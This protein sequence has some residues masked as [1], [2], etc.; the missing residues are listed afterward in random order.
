VAKY[1]TEI[2][3]KIDG[4]E[5]S[6]DFEK[7][8]AEVVVDTSLHLPDMFA[9]ELRD[10]DLKW[11]DESALLDIGNEVV[12]SFKTAEEGA[13]GGLAAQLITG[14]ITAIEPRF[15]W[16]GKTSLMIRGYD[17][18]HR[19]HRGKQTRTF[20][21]KKDSQV[22][23]TIAGE[24]G[25]TASADATS[26]TYDY[27][28]QSNQTNMEF[29]T[30][31]AER[32]GYQVYC[33][34]GTLFFKKGDAN[35]GDGPTLE[36]GDDLHSFRPRWT[37][38][39]QAD[40]VV[41]RSW[42]PKNKTAI[43]STTSPPGT[44]NQGG[45]TATGGS[46]ASSAFSSATQVVADRPV[47]TADEASEIATGLS[48]DISREFVQAEGS[49]VGN[50]ELKA[51][52][53]IMIEG[54]GTRFSGYYLVTSA[55]HI[56]NK[57]G[58]ETEFSMTGRHP[59]TISHLLGV[60]GNGHSLDQGRVMGV[61]P[62]LVTNVNDPDDLGRVKVKYAWLGDDIESD[63]LRIAAP[64]AG[65]ERGM[66]Y[67]P[68]V[69]DE[70]L[71]AFE[72]GDIHRPYLIGA[73]WSST[74]KP[75]KPISEVAEGGKVNL[76]VIKSRAG[77][78]VTLDDTE[79]AEQVSVTSKSGHTVILDDKDGSESITIK[80]KT[81]KNSM[82]IDSTKNSLTINVEGDFVVNAKGKVSI[83]STQDMTLDSKAK[84]NLTSM[85]GTTLDSKGT[86]AFKGMSVE[87]NGQTTLK[88]SGSIM[89]EV[90]GGIVKIN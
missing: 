2:T 29:L 14:E 55:T 43:Q 20:L 77:H 30:S 63:W 76:R 62:A 51:G 88:L 68:E 50:P 26:V 57:D 12:I 28:L 84:A 8:L 59:N 73:L 39:N 58:Y 1:S 31:R 72:Q 69:G 46:K 90:K 19:L 21:Q 45:M 80:D 4:T 65:A 47:F 61:A 70:V 82:V 64:M 38:A 83:N 3:I 23:D 27:I 22:V 85:S 71:I 54:V 66:F 16:D 15:S 78:L 40:S 86:A 49:C 6:K 44:L 89:T 81:G 9:I 87:V 56:W 42:D 79:G 74:D 13:W 35:L 52:W 67:L 10:H 36:Y 18:S 75:P 32:I 41:V 37:A 7:D 33:A 48:N 53:R 60:D 17:K 24:V 11:V 25:L 5:V 34:D